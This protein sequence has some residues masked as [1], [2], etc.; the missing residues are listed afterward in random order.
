MNPD[1]SIVTEAIG[2]D[3]SVTMNNKSMVAITGDVKIIASDGQITIISEKDINVQSNAG[4][5]RVLAPR[6]EINA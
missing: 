5:V 1:G 4:V 3:L 2:D 6:V